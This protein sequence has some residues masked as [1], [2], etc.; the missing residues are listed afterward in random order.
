MD[1][2]VVMGINMGAVPNP[3]VLIPDLQ[4]MELR[5]I[6]MPPASDNARRPDAGKRH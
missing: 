1:L 2:W 5:I 4:T 6:V 3:A